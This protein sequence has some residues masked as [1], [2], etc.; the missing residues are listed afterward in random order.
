MLGCL[1]A[2]TPAFSQGALF[3]F[4][5]RL[6]STGLDQRLLERTVE[7]ARRRGGFEAKSLRLA[8]DS[9]PLWGRGRLEDTLNLLGHDEGVI[10]A[11]TVLPANT[12]DTA[13]LEPLLIAVELQQRQVISLHI[14]RG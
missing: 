7:L 10:L 11:A 4:W 8:L 13:G 2:E 3:D 9:S 5:M 12:P 14:D 1:G 6:L